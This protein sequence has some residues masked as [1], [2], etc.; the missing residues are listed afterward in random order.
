MQTGRSSRV[1]DLGN[2]MEDMK[3]SVAAGN[4]LS[5]KELTELF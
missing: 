2:D 3:E 4:R 5:E 1:K